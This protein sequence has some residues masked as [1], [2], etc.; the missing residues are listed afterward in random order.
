[1]ATVQEF[2]LTD[3]ALVE[4]K[5]GNESFTYETATEVNTEV[6]IT[7][8]SKQELIIKGVLVAS[9]N[10]PDVI[11]GVTITTKN[12]T[13]SP[14][15][16][17]LYQGGEVVENA[18]EFVSYSAPLAGVKPS[19]TK[20]D[21]INIYT[22]ICEAGGFTG[23]YMKVSFPN[24]QGKPMNLQF[25]DGA[26]YSNECVLTTTPNKGQAPYTITKVSTL[27]ATR[28]LKQEF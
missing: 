9:K 12:N 6:N 1:M 19:V 23:D 5:V 21:E 27:P 13:F 25:A 16:I 28:M 11:T 15:I 4:L 24:G 20:I 8:G 10:T 2:P 18:G 26:F 7:E 22:E 17:E 14:K 3:V